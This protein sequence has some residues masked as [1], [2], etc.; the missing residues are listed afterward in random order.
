L[1]LQAKY[2]RE[3]IRTQKLQILYVAAGIQGGFDFALPEILE[4]AKS[5]NVLTFVDLIQ[6]YDKGWEFII[7]ALRY[8]DIFHC[9]ITE[10]LQ[11]YPGN[12]VRSALRS[13]ASA[14]TKLALVTAGDK[15]I[16]VK[17]RTMKL[18]R[19]PA[20]VVKPVDP[21][22]AGDAF[23]AAIIHK[24]FTPDY[25]KCMGVQKDITRLPTELLVELIIF[26]QACGAVCTTG[27]GTTTAVNLET[28]QKLL[29]EHRADLLKTTEI[30]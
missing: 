26:G 5:Q 2:V 1:S 16:Y 20:F 22:G 13:V 24:L 18:I 17:T 10:L 23:C 9:N 7:P 11:I 14:G 29:A 3:I 25:V 21:T 6:P 19:Q 8:T 15:G 12:N 28:V 30:I 4:F 27:I